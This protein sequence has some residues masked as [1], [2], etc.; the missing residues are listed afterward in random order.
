MRLP[1][2]SLSAFKGGIL[3]TVS[4][5]SFCPVGIVSCVGAV[6]SLNS[7]SESLSERKSVIFILLYVLWAHDRYAGI[8]IINWHKQFAWKILN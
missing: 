6:T 2:V 7:G 4:D 3:D 8:I 5:V 1:C